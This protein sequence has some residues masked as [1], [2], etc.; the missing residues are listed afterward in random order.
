MALPLTASAFDRIERFSDPPTIDPA[1]PQR[2]FNNYSICTVIW[3]D[4]HYRSLCVPTSKNKD[5]VLEQL[6]ALLQTM[7]DYKYLLKYTFIRRYY[8]EL[9]FLFPTSF[10]PLFDVIYSLDNVTTLFGQILKAL[11]FLTTHALFHGHIDQDT[12]F[13]APSSR[14]ALLCDTIIRCLSCVGDSAAV[15]IVADH[16]LHRATRRSA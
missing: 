13:Y 12:V 2:S 15:F 14:S 16:G 1:F 10:T 9:W 8:D 4:F 11:H 3:N 5:L 7:K 6:L